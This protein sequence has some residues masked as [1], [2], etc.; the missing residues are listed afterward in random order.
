MRSK[1]AECNGSVFKSV[2]TLVGV[3]T[4]SC[5]GLGVWLTE[6]ARMKVMVV[7]SRGAV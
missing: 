5:R 3:S 2:D 1:R 4:L 6:R 7:Q